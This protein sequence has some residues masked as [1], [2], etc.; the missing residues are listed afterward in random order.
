MLKY[1]VCM[2]DDLN[3]NVCYNMIMNNWCRASG[4][5]RNNVSVLRER[6]AIREGM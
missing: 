2:Y 1:L 4:E 5:L 6:I 3:V